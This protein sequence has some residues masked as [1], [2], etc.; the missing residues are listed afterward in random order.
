MA[1]ILRSQWTELIASA[2]GA[3]TE[4][5]WIIEGIARDEIC[6]G[7]L[8]AESK[9]WI[10]NAFKEAMRMFQANE[11]PF[12]DLLSRVERRWHVGRAG[13]RRRKHGD[14][15]SPRE[16]RRRVPH[17]E[18]GRRL[19]G[20]RRRQR[21]RDRDRPAATVVGEPSPPNIARSRAS[22]RGF[23]IL[24]DPPLRKFAKADSIRAL[25]EIVI[26]NVNAAS[27]SGACTTGSKEFVDKN[28]SSTPHSRTT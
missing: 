20:V 16:V 22:A 23:R 3:P 11:A 12:R 10:E 1:Q 7:T 18:V 17:R 2:T 24:R 13:R 8:D 28:H 15:R 14:R 9:I 25:L 19:R 6:D 27:M 5:V 26:A 21:E 4:V